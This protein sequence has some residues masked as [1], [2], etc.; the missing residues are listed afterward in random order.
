M[1]GTVAMDL[2]KAAEEFYAIG[3]NQ[4]NNVNPIENTN[5]KSEDGV[6]TIET[7]LKK[8]IFPFYPSLA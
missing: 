5:L 4:I 3:I 7:N 2:K 8:Y 6:I 1:S